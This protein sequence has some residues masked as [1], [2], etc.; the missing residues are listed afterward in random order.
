MSILLSFLSS[1]IRKVIL[2][3]VSL[4]VPEILLP[5]L[6]L[7]L[8][9]PNLV[10][11]LPNKHLLR[12]DLLSNLVCFSLQLSLLLQPVVNLIFSRSLYIIQ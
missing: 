12:F 8:Q 4:L 2:D 5:L 11:D 3:S 1:F 6:D 7:I 9:M 10:L